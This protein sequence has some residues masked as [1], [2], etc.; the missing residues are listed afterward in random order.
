MSEKSQEVYLA[1]FEARQARIQSMG[2][3]EL[4][5]FIERNKKGDKKLDKTAEI[6]ILSLAVVFVA[7]ATAMW[8]LFGGAMLV[9]GWIVVSAPFLFVIT[10]QIRKHYDLDR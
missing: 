10:R 9:G 3:H 4:D 1:R 6:W 7:G 2:Q 8:D 5:V